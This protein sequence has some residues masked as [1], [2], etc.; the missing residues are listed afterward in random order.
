MA[1]RLGQKFGADPTHL[2]DLQARFD[3][4]SYRERTSMAPRLHTPSV[5]TIKAREIAQWAAGNIEARHD[6]PVLIRRLVNSTS[7]SVTE[8]DFPGYDNAQWKGW[9][10][11]VQATFGTP[12]LPEGKSGWEL[13]CR[14]HPRSK[15]NGDYTARTESVAES[16]RRALSFVFVTPHE[17][18]G[19]ND[20]ADGKRRLGDWKHVRAYDASDLEQWIETSAATQV[21]F[22]EHLGRPVD[23]YHSLARFWEDWASAAEPR[24]SRALFD[25][26]VEEHAGRFLAW[27][28]G[29]PS[30]PFTIAADSRGE[31]IAFLACLLEAEQSQPPT[32]ERAIVFDDA[33]ALKRLVAAEPGAFLAIAGT[34]DVERG[35]ASLGR[36]HCVAPQF[37]RPS[38]LIRAGHDIELR[39]LTPRDFRVALGEMDIGGAE[40][41]RYARI[42][43]RAPT[44]LRRR[45]AKTPENRRPP[46]ANEP[47]TEWVVTPALVGAWH[48]KTEADRR[49]I[50]SISGITYHEFESRF[51]K[52]LR[53]ED[54]PVWSVGACQGAC[55]RI[56]ILESSRYFVRPTDLDR[57]FQLAGSV[58]SEGDS[59]AYLADTGGRMASGTG[60]ARTYSHGLRQAVRETLILLAEH[61]DCWFDVGPGDSLEHRVSQ[62]VRDLLLPLTVEKLLSHSGDLAD[63]AEA[64]PSTFL[65]VLER[66]LDGPEPAVLDLLATSTGE[67]LWQPPARSELLWALE[68]LAWFPN[69]EHGVAGVSLQRISD[70]L[71]R[72]AKSELQDRWAN[73]PGRTLASLFRSWMPQTSASLKQRLATLRKLISDHPAVG[74]CLCMQLLPK[75]HD[76]AGPECLPRWRGD[77]SSA[78]KGA[79]RNE[80]RATIEVV[81]R[82][83]LNW[84]DHDEQTLGDLIDR[85]ETFREEDQVA[86]WARV[87]EWAVTASDNE[88]ATL[89]D[90]IRKHRPEL[91]DSR[92][93]EALEHLTPE[94]AVAKHRWLFTAGW[95]PDLQRTRRE[96]GLDEYDKQLAARRAQALRE[97]LDS[98]GRAGLA[99]LIEMCGK[100]WEVGY[101]LEKVLDADALA[102]FV[103]ESLRRT[104]ERAYG[105]CMR[106]LLAAARQET[107]EGLVQRQREANDETARL[108]LFL[109]M[110]FRGTT[111]R[112]V[113]QENAAT[114]ASYWL[115]VAPPDH[116]VGPDDLNEALDRLLQA[117]RPSAAFRVALSFEHV[118]TERLKR[119]LHD[120]AAKPGAPP[121]RDHQ[122]ADAL[123][124]LERRLEVSSAELAEIEFALLPFLWLSERGVPKL[125]ERVIESPI[126]FAQ[127]VAFGYARTDDGE[128]P[129]VWR[130]EDPER[131]AVLGDSYRCLLLRL[132]RLPGSA[133]SSE[134]DAR[135]LGKWLFATRELC[136][137]L[138]RSEVADAMIGEWL[139][140]ASAKDGVVRPCRAVAEAIEH[141]KSEDVDRGF[142]IGARNVRG[143][144]FRQIDGGG[145]PEREL[146]N[147]YR[148]LA[149]EATAEWPRMGRLLEEVAQSFDEESQRWDRGAKVARRV[150]SHGPVFDA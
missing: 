129:P 23:G 20:W 54:P 44:I 148:L 115:R 11:T 104:R 138:G 142:R 62:L 117:E 92:A 85:I 52:L 64:A 9:D 116:Y 122:L 130:V 48:S 126:L 139:A 141:M 7:T 96:L 19:K 108:E 149:R 47:D 140:R 17:W 30:R 16:E 45:L 147:T 41:D 57:F 59:Q 112:L 113:S 114:R 120:L 124:S 51:L 100:P 132:H 121:P 145:G 87:S 65:D 74:W 90:R 13:S 105:E 28:S 101:L 81:R 99:E 123:E 146:S 86:V 103:D 69:E 111:W 26:A 31:A 98:R 49:A 66:D 10:G 119:L 27:L 25:C 88:K 60:E 109:A 22:A 72:L 6:L 131:R 34:A 127:A 102:A 83:A 1:R 40:A 35:F 70:A 58:L 97:I 46:W 8:I 77:I 2:R 79:P 3:E 55:S 36:Q 106:G 42:S 71:A 21:W 95:D 5:A 38:P 61:G 82:F 68:R 150:P 143:V 43:A 12:W 75:H 93:A 15:A 33:N 133:E 39:H 67:G 80:V 137:T 128:D 24:L 78:G 32:L 107:I 4:A 118:E 73:T 94:D 125:E 84:S 53:L 135:K 91:D 14:R 37:V 18:R 63:L 110:P 29:E 136:A 50:E 134:V 144:S 56:D 76:V 89:K